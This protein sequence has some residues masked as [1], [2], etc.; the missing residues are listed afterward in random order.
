[1]VSDLL[2]QVNCFHSLQRISFQAWTPNNFSKTALSSDQNFLFLEKERGKGSMKKNSYIDL[3]AAYNIEWQE[4]QYYAIGQKPDA[5]RHKLTKES[6]LKVLGRMESKLRAQSYI[7][8]QTDKVWETF[9]RNDI[10]YYSGLEPIE[11][12]VTPQERG[13]AGGDLKI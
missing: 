6:F 12:V 9:T 3:S 11:A 2:S 4:L 7:W 1:M 5:Y 10:G 8:V 13:P